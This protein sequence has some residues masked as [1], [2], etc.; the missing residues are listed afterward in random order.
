[1]IK[2][3]FTFEN[4]TWHAQLHNPH[5]KV[6]LCNTCTHRSRALFLLIRK[7]IMNS[8]QISQSS[9]FSI[10]KMLPNPHASILKYNMNIKRI[11][12]DRTWISSKKTFHKDRPVCSFSLT[13]KVV[14]VLHILLLHPPTSPQSVSPLYPV[15]T[16]CW[17][18]QMR[19]LSVA[20]PRGKTHA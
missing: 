3:S 10:N 11:P 7:F 17:D 8:S 20:A 13:S 19:P 5:G 9:T 12:E 1:M 18:P 15:P 2:N 4:L 16:T 6:F 14:H